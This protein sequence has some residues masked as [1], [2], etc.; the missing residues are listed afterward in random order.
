M[1]ALASCEIFLL[2][3]FYFLYIL[4]FPKKVAEQISASYSVLN[5]QMCFQWVFL[6]SCLEL[7]ASTGGLTLMPSDRRRV[8]AVF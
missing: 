8:G 3:F 5:I 1:S 6:L 2:H 7:V 4:R